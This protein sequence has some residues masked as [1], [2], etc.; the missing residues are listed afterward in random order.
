MYSWIINTNLKVIL[1]YTSPKKIA[2]SCKLYFF[3]IWGPCVEN[4]CILL[5]LLFRKKANTVMKLQP[6]NKNLSLCDKTNKVMTQSSKKNPATNSL[7]KRGIGRHSNTPTSS[8]PFHQGRSPPPSL[9]PHRSNLLT[10]RFHSTPPVHINKNINHRISFQHFTQNFKH[11]LLY[12]FW[13]L[14]GTLLYK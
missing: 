1:Y 7:N 12:V 13:I 11:D 9:L 2:F 6:S 14:D 8:T 5:V 4:D 10:I 3:T